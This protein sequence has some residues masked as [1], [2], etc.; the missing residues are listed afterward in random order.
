MQ[1]AKQGSNETSTHP[2]TPEMQGR[3][4]AL[5]RRRL[6]LPALLFL[7]AHR[8]LAFLAG[9]L[10]WMAQ[11]VSGL[12]LLSPEMQ[13]ALEDWAHLLSHPQGPLALEQVLATQFYHHGQL[14]D[15]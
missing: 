7:S 3:I 1:C 11:P 6:L 8:P 9:Q 4:E 12:L 14:R 5:A 10:L 15:A 2:I 13:G